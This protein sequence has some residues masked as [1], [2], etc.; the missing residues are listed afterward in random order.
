MRSAL[1]LGVVL[2]VGAFAA[3]AMALQSVM[4]PQPPG[5]GTT[6]AQV[7]NDPSQDPFTTDQSNNKSNPFSSFHFNVTSGQDWPGEPY[8]AYRPQN[9][10]PD[11]YGSAATPGSEFS[12]SNTFYPH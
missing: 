8:H 11:A 4:L 6:N 2:M 10:T 7:P 12:T 3:P 1:L 9:A 5:D